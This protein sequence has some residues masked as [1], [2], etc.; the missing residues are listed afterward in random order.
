MTDQVD[1]E[2]LT[3]Y[4]KQF[5]GLTPEYEALLQ[6]SGSRVEGRLTE[7]TDDFYTALLEIDKTW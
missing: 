4:A 7:V 2:A 1:F 3:R 5:S 6:E